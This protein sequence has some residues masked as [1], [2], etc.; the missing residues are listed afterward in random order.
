VADG[1][2]VAGQAGETLIESLLS[3][4]IVTAIAIA[5]FLGLRVAIRSS[6]LHKESAVA[7]TLLR[8]AAEQLQDPDSAYEPLAGCSG[9]APYGDLLP[10][11]SGYTVAVSEVR[12]WVPPGPG[13]APPWDTEFAAPGSPGDCPAADPGLQRLELRVDTPTGFAQ[14]LHVVK[15]RT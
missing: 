12:F 4:T 11:R 15:R 8:T 5:A 2:R 6:A 14:T 10:T 7:E 13:D 9:G 3:I 1:R